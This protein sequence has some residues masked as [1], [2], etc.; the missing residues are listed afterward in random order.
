MDRSSGEATRDQARSSARPEHVLAAPLLTFDLADEFER[1]RREGPY[2]EHRRNAKTLVKSDT[3]RI[4]VAALRAGVR[5]DEGDPRGH[6]GLVVQDG[7]VS[8][9]VGDETVRL[10]AGSVAAIEPGHEWWAQ[11]DEDTLL[12]LHLAWPT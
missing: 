7:A 2:A 6:V 9:T 8:L 12:V 10:G 5:F 1:L 11:A 3:F 4:V